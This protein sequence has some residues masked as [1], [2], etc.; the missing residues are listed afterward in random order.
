MAPLVTDLLPHPLSPGVQAAF[1]AGYGLLLLGTLLL[2]L[3]HRRRFFVSERWNGYAGS[4]RWTDAIQNP[5][6]CPV[7]LTGWLLSAAL[8]A[9]GTLTLAAAG[10]NLLLC[11][12]FFVQMRWKGILR[13]MGA[14]GF[15]TYWLAAAVFLLE[16]TGR[17]APGAGGLALLTLQ[18]DFA[19]II[20]SAGVYKLSAGYAKNEGMEYGLV[21]PEWGYWWRTYARLSPRH[22]LFPALNH[23]AWATEIVAAILMLFPPTRMCG[24][25]LIAVSFA[26]I[27]TQIRLGL[28][29]E[30][31]MLC[32]L[33]YVTPGSMIDGWL[34]A[35][36]SSPALPGVAAASSRVVGLEV[37]LWGY[38]ALL[39]LAHAGLYYNLYARRRLCWP[40][41]G[42]LE[43]YTGFF[44]IIIWRV[45]SVDLVNF[46]IRIYR[47][48]REAEARILLTEYGWRGGVRYSH[49][50]ESIT[51]TSLFTTLK[52]Y[53]GDAALFRERL[54]RYA[55]TV[56]CPA[57]AL[58]IFEY[59]SI[60]K[61]ESCFVFEPVAEYEVD[62]LAERVAE[63][64]VRS[65]ISVRAAHP[66]SP[67][68]TGARPGSYAPLAGRSGARGGCSE[69]V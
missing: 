53:P 57:D 36:V 16:L 63:R 62:A 55:R 64:V 56:A 38:L 5:A 61:H 40:L 4:S 48:P 65:D 17:Y 30:M 21:N 42:A 9:T 29:C 44:G 3:P 39:P 67:V 59:V 41:Q 68:Q 15:M 25:L 11:R 10:I 6:A 14:P 60:T 69:E 20:L 31:V 22:P 43:A 13:G 51:L 19:C 37:A 34:G 26:F 45:F 50:G 1:R 54:R 66:A 2:A 24:G 23:L 27:A 52:Y 58:L 28:L 33:L 18:V 46:F 47:R 35:L 7:I 49:V 32:G 8:I 12:Y